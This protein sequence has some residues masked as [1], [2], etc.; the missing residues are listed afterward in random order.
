MNGTATISARAGSVTQNVAINVAQS[1]E[2]IKLEPS[3]ATLIAAGQ[4]VQFSATVLDRNGHPI[5][6]AIVAW[7]SSD[8]AVATV[9]D[10]GLVT[11][12]MNGTATITA[13]VGSVTQNAAVNVAQSAERITLEPSMATLIAA[14]QTVQLSA[15]VLDRN[16]HPL[17][18]AV[19]AWESSDAAVATVSDEGHVTAVMEGM[20][21]I[22][23]RS[24]SVAK[25]APVTVVFLS[26]DRD[27][28]VALYHAT[29]G[30]IWKNNM[31]WLGDRPFGEWYGITTDSTG[32]VTELALQE[33]RLRGTIPASIEKLDN[34]HTLWLYGNEL[35]G[36]IPGATGN[37]GNLVRLSLHANELTGTIP[38]EIGQLGNLERL[39]LSDND[40]SGTIP[41]ELGQ[42]SNLEFLSLGG[43]SLSGSLPEE[44]GRLSRLTFLW[45]NGNA[46]LSGPLPLTFADL[47]DLERL[48]VEGTGLCAP[49]DDSFQT[50]LRQVPIKHGLLNC[51]P[52]Q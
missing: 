49:A 30:P 6:D 45:L 8:A 7:E 35:S 3:M 24:G 38:L 47:A 52:G 19:I 2:S 5:A 41:R 10:E 12:V 51:S 13:R 39:F 33:N 1:A 31:H 4:T 23:A 43:N 32:R 14:G 46:H 50:W 36:G 27:A 20:A 48:Y 26:R 28:L 15:T 40:L 42:L 16:G 21:T 29:G 37:L 22:T 25:S 34:L 44:I 18:D 17:A 11:A 9:S